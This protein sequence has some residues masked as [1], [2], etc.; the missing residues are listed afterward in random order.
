MNPVR[1]KAI[2]AS[3]P[4][5]YTGILGIYIPFTGEAN[6]NVAAPSFVV[7]VSAAHEQMHQKGYSREDEA[8]FLS[9]Q[10]LSLIHISCCAGSIHGSSRL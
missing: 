4:F 8:N 9:I 10:A 5:S 3:A 2:L 6:L 1:P 7:A